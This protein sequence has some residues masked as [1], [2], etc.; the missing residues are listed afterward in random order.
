MTAHV[1]HWKKDGKAACG[2]LRARHLATDRADVSCRSCLGSVPAMSWKESEPRF[3]EDLRA[4]LGPVPIDVNQAQLDAAELFAKALQ[5][6][7]DRLRAVVVKLCDLAESLASE[8]QRMGDLD[9]HWQCA[10]EIA[11]QG[12]RLVAER[13]EAT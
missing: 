8:I 6:E 2:T 12:A 4:K 9:E 7:H 3:L 10:I 5:R 11:I 1:T 13:A